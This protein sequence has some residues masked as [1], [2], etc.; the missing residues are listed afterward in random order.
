MFIHLEAQQLPQEMKDVVHINASELEK[1][2]SRL[3]SEHFE[4]A[5]PR[6]FVKKDSLNA[7]NGLHRGKPGMLKSLCDS[8]S[9]VP[10]CHRVQAA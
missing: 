3:I 7:L 9:P 1:I 10:L 2:Q 6:I 8:V 4:S 5:N